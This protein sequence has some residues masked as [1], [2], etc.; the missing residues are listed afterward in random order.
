M[1][2]AYSSLGRTKVL[3]ATSLVL[4]GA[5]AKFL[6]RK[7]SVLVALEE[8]SEMCWLF[9]S[10]IPQAWALQ[11]R[12]EGYS[13][14][15]GLFVHYFFLASGDFCCLLKTFANSLDSDT[16]CPSWSGSKLLD[17][18]I[19]FWKNFLKKLIWKKI[20]RRKITQHAKLTPL[21]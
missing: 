2:A 4:R 21:H 7:P 16:E 14:N 8:I 9:L 12:K 3:Y 6:R 19:F 18:L 13:N 20:S 15:M 17:T 11:V 1:G 5:K 10:S